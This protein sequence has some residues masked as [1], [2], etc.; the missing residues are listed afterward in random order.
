ME[1]QGSSPDLPRLFLGRPLLS[2]P[3]YRVPLDRP[4]VIKDL[5]LTGQV[6]MLAGQP[7]IG[8]S[9]VIT[10]LAASV[11]LGRNIGPLRVRRSLVLYV[12]AEDPEGIAERSAGYWQQAPGDIAHFYIHGWPVDLTDAAAMAEFKRETASLKAAL[13]AEQ[14]LIIF[15]TLNLCIGDSDENS[16]R[17]MGAAVANPREVARALNAHVMLVHHTSAGD[18]GKARGSSALPANI[19]TLLMLRRVEEHEDRSIVILTQEKQ[20]SV[21]KGSPLI[22][23]NSSIEYGRD[24]DN[25]PRTAPISRY[26]APTPALLNKIN[27]RRSASDST[28]DRAEEVLRVLRALH[29]KAPN[30]CHDAKAIAARVGESFEAVR[31]NP[32]S[33]R[34]AVRRALDALIGEGK[35]E[36][37]TNGGYRIAKPSAPDAPS[38]Q[39]L[40]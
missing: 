26:A 9:S 38:H 16:S 37:D 25:E 29:A 2:A 23:E 33:F 4:Y 15:D 10:S 3:D 34:K 30:A 28:D 39:N 13:E 6:S 7:N 27:G 19:D 22:F 31:S 18:Q 21:R 40:H 17:D 20:R 32:D 35:V 11:A 5:L 36:A 14:L 8:K 12:A 1:P 24:R